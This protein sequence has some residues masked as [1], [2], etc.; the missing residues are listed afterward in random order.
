MLVRQVFRWVFLLPGAIDFPPPFTALECTMLRRSAARILVLT[1]LLSAAC[2]SDG[3]GG[4][5]VVEAKNQ[6]TWIDVAAGVQHTCAVN[7]ANVAWCW[8]V[9]DQGQLGNGATPATSPPV[10]VSGNLRFRSIGAG[11]DYS[12]GLT[13][14]GQVYCWGSNR[15]NQLG[16][17]TATN[18]V[19]LAPVP[20]PGMTGIR[21]LFVGYGGVFAIA[22]D[23]RRFCWGFGCRE[24]NVPPL[25]PL[26]V[27]VQGLPPLKGMASHGTHWCGAGALRGVACW[28]EGLRQSLGPLPPDFNESRDYN[29]VMTGTAFRAAAAGYSHSCGLESGGAVYCWGHNGYGQLGLGIQEPSSDPFSGRAPGPAVLG[30]QVFVDLFAGGVVTCGLTADGVAYCWGG[31]AVGQVGAGSSG[32]VLS[33]PTRVAGDLKFR[34]LS[35]GA[36]GAAERQHVCGITIAGRLYCWGSG[37]SGAAGTRVQLAATSP[38][39]VDD[40]S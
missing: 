11:A 30:G 17:G 27:L 34:K 15:V 2:N 21:E 28:G 14:G 19:A 1:G 9:G 33:A 7:T 12:C 4:D 13:V 20:V 39:E 32:A 25:Y 38:Q 10:A 31:N 29:L 23:D 18:L 40:P 26:P 36:L 8:G 35:I 6:M 5:P 24:G 3:T 16:N 37:S 22:E